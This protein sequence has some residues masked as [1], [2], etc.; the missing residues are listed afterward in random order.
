M[1]APMNIDER[2]ALDLHAP[3]QSVESEQAVLGGLMIDN[4]AL[5]LIVDTLREAD[6]YRAD[7]RTI[8]RAIVR[9][10]ESGREADVI[11]VYEALVAEKRA[12][13]VGGMVYLNELRE[14]TPSAAN[15]R[16][17]AKRVKDTAVLRGLMSVGQQAIDAATSN[18]RGREVE[19]LVGEIEL[20]VSGLM[21]DGLTGDD[22]PSLSETLARVCDEI[23]ERAEHPER[24]SGL[25]TGLVALDALLDGMQPADL[26]ILAGRPSMGKSALGFQI[27]QRAALAGSVVQAFSLEMPRAALVRRMLANDARADGEAMKNGTLTD[28]DFSN[29]ARARERLDA[30]ALEI[31]DRPAL[32]IGQMRARCRRARR[33][34]GRLDLVIVDYLQLA[35]P[36][37]RT[38]NRAQ[39]VGEI[40]RGLK[41]LAKEMGCPLIALAQINRGVENRADRRPQMSDL[42]DSGEIEQDAD[43][44]GL[45]YRDEYYY[46]DSEANKGLLEI[47]IKKN[48]NGSLA[49]LTMVWLAHCTRIED[50]ER[51]YVA[52][53]RP[54]RDFKD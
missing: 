5:D 1:N 21:E 20:A 19:Q 46:P 17:Y 51:R 39:D 15:I 14:N 8:W 16:A 9:E 31:D 49:R 12:D 48:R 6:F 43:I 36:T 27:G 24:M 42:R 29:I 13:E 4:R 18:R 30:C 7:H 44:I 10:I 45:L 50:T 11:T 38:D 35:S 47:D 40:S 37:R 3:P 32:T 23:Q 26:I 41:A 34:F 25:S 53:K 28:R 2:T 52:P 33:K 22:P 54:A